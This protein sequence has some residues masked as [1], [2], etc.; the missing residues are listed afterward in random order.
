MEGSMKINILLLAVG[1]GMIML[2]MFSTSWFGQLDW[3]SV[4]LSFRWAVGAS[5]FCFL[6]AGIILGIRAHHS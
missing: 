1:I 5:Q 3:T 6:F 4:P 2:G